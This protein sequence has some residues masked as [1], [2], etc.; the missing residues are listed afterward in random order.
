MENKNSMSRVERLH[1]EKVTRYSIRKY[2]FG[3]ASVAVAALFMFLGNGAVS[4]DMTAVQPQDESGLKAKPTDE[5]AELPQVEKEVAQPAES[6]PA[7]QPI[8]EEPTAKP[9]EPA[10]PA[11]DKKQLENYIAEI[12]AKLSNGSYANKTDESVAVLKA[13][14]EAAKTTLA[15]AT[16]QDELTKAY[17][18]LVTTANTKLKNKPVEK[19]ETSAVDTTNG[20]E[21]VGKKAE[22]T[23]KK[24]D[25]NAIENTGSNDARN[26][27]ALDKNNAFRAETT[28]KSGNFTYSMEYSTGKEIYLYNEE[29]ANVNI[30]VNSTAG[31]ITKA[32]VKAGSG[33]FLLKSKSDQAIAYTKF[34]RGSMPPEEEVER[35][36]Y[37][38]S[39]RQTLTETPGPVTINITGKPNDKFKELKSY[40]KTEDQHAVLGAR[41]LQ[42]EDSNGNRLS[43][44]SNLNAPGAFNLVVK[45]QTYKYDIKD[46]T[47]ERRITVNDINNITTTDLTTIKS[48]LKLEYSKKSNDARFESLKGT[49]VTN[50]T[51]LID[52]VA[53]STTDSSKLVVTYVDGSTDE[54]EKSKV[55]NVKPAGIIPFSNPTTK[56]IYVYKGE[57]TNL[58][59]GV[60]DDSGK[61]KDLRIVQGSANINNS[62]AARGQVKNEYGL[63]MTSETNGNG[64]VAT[65]ANPA[66]TRITGTISVPGKPNYVGPLMTRYLVAEDLDGAIFSNPDANKNLDQEG[67]FK[68]VVREQ[69]QKFDI[70]GQTEENNKIAVSDVNNLS[71]A[72]FENIKNN[73]K[74][75][76][77]TSDD[78]RLKD[79]DGTLVENASQYIQSITKEGDK[80]VVTY[81]DGSTDKLELSSVVRTNPAPTVEL[82]YSNADKRQIYVYSGENT[83]LTFKASDDAALKKVYLRGPGNKDFDN[84]TS[85]GFTTGKINDGALESGEGTVSSDKQNATIKMTGVT[86]LKAGAKWTSIIVAQDE[87]DA[88]SIDNFNST[89]DFAERQQRPGYV[90]FIVKDQTSKYDI[91]A[92]TEKVAVTDP[93]NVT[94]DELAKIKEKLQLE[95]KKD[96][97]DANVAK[98]ADVTDKDAKI[99]SVTKDDQG[100]LVVT[101]KD[102][103]KDTRPLSEF[104]TL[105]KQPAIDEVNKAAEKQIEAINKTPNAT[106]EEKQAAIDKVNADKKKALDEIAKPEVT[107]KDA[108]DKAQ[109]SGT[110]AIAKD[111]PVVAKKDEAKADVEAARKAKEDAIKANPNLSDEEKD[112]AIAKVNKVAEDAKKAIDAATSNA[113]VETAKGTGT[114]AIDN[115]TPVAKTAAKKAIADALTA[116][117]AELDKRTDLTDEEKT[118]AKAEAQKLAD[119]QLAEI[120]KQPDAADTKEAAKTA[121][122]A[123]NAAGTKGAADVAAVNP[124]AKSKPAAKKAI[125]DKLAEQLKTI[126]N[127]PDATTD[128]K[129]VAADAAK[130]L[131]DEAK[132]EIDKAG[133]DAEVK[134]LQDEAKK[135][136]EKSVPVV[137][138]KPNA[139]KAIDDEATAKKAAIDARDDLTPKAKEDLKAQVDKI[140]EQ[141][142][143]SVDAAKTAEAVNGIEES[144]K[145]AIKAVGEVNIPADKVLVND[146]SD[147]TDAEK[148]K[149]LEAVKKVNPDAKE[150]TQDADG[151]ITVT[152]PDGHQEI[153]TPEQVVKTA[154]TANDPKA[155]NDVVKP[156]DKVVVNDPAKLTDAEKEKIKAAVEA[157]NPN[158]IVVVDDKGNAKVSTPDGQTQVIPVEDLVRT[159]EDTKKPNAGD[160]I[161]KPADKTVVANPDALTPEEKKAIEDKV[162]AVN[163]G[164]TVVVD[165][166]GNATVT[167]PEGKTAVIPATDLTKSAADAAKPNAGNDIV[168]PAAKT[169]V[170][171]PDALTS[172][173]KKAIED[174]VK[175][176]NPG[177]TVVVDDK[178]NATVTTPEGKTAVIPATDLV[179]TQ[180]DITKENAG[181]DVNTP[182]AKTV[183]A[184]PDALTSEE[185]K[186]IED[187]V[188]AVN[189]GST[190]VVDDKGNATVA[191]G[192]GTVLNIPALDLVIPA[193]DLA[194]AAKNTAVKTPAIRTLV[195]D[196]EKLTDAEK[197]AVK[198]AIEAVNPGATVVVDDKGNAT[199]TLDGNTVSIAKDQLVKT[200]S[201]VTAKNSGDNINLDFEKETVADLN[202]LTDAEKE[203]AKAKIKGAN[204]DV[205]EVIFDK[206]GN[207]TVVTKDGKVLAIAAEDIF[208]QRPS[209]PNNGGNGTSGNN[210]TTN[211]DVKVDKA[212][213]EG[214]IRQLDELIIKESAK[215]DAETAKEA[216]DL[217]ADAKK[218]F[219]NADASQAE[220]DAMVKRIEDFMAKV[221]P[222]TDHATPAN[223]Q[224]AQTP[225]VA[226]ATTQAAANASQTA[227]AQ[228]N[229]RTVAKELP[230]TGTADSVVSMV[231]AAASALLGLGLAGRRRKE[232]EEA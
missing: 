160:D 108:L 129:K 26:G 57:E 111:N 119:A 56:E 87:D 95:Y 1:R 189:P 137:E 125:D 61:V 196:K 16:S 132:E 64:I 70:Q 98:D 115:V 176:V 9:A 175:A 170:A 159:V 102:G 213:L 217:L 212:K 12:E 92:P 100:N 214:A 222:S 232:D 97:D 144:D 226:S 29:E 106:D 79:K 199:V 44:G 208:K 99:D 228:A 188:K 147:L 36:D 72:D 37:G 166:K 11:L 139:R 182:A 22:N 215:L 90:E 195:A 116:K 51:S 104:V 138:D 27:Q 180:D 131:A 218:V 68:L 148:A 197:A 54:I 155:G 48:R 127:T 200:A 177:S 113:D 43:G 167:T 165:D 154:D 151:N 168:K 63:T 220:V 81:K 62:G 118:A 39:Y 120:A 21:T 161:V 130:A 184:N 207:A 201:D 66:T 78:E 15:N 210:G 71:D 6:T 134:Q 164:S 216:N 38:W 75:Q 45:S 124:E 122:D 4:A 183:V 67:A 32:T 219:A 230:N 85:F 93:A 143:K 171:N 126:E 142:K 31:N 221:A 121:Q 105:D 190:V 40:T 50:P 110:D 206:A 14:L 112:A 24:S 47:E 53:V 223:D 42:L 60:T 185:K 58:E 173:E 49:E 18:K 172:E 80:I 114:T 178:G 136:I 150:I 227:S 191:K 229:T 117:T 193:D 174:K 224:A 225:V 101:Y 194:D 74:I 3:A 86:S 96:N 149:V 204:A 13:D 156:A 145:A 205:V 59:F 20:K 28:E 135:E 2:S 8:A 158:S 187:K 202:N 163:P 10:T 33:Q 69:T 35:D 17:N 181:N 88:R 89:E 23:E 192:D 5:N 133:T 7:A 107:T 34:R 123:V 140:A 55:L 91:K 76:Y 141:A 209:A 186:A 109:K 169:V 231:A 162:K 152:T 52:T 19:K 82:P 73:I 84:A 83:D 103:S 77:K 65:T 146:P 25:S 94:K 128:E 211:T 203:A 179:K 41:Y 30:T 153:I 198:K 46:L 157:V